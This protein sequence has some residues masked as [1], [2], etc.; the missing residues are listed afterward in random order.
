MFKAKILKLN[1][2]YLY[3]VAKLMHKHTRKK[4]LISLFAFFAPVK[5]IHTQSA[6][7][8]SSKSNLCQ[9]RY[10]SH[11]LQKNF[12]YQAVKMWNSLRTTKHKR[13]TLQS[14]Q[15]KLQK[16]FTFKYKSIYF[17]H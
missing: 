1:D 15:D 16:I 7:L 5:T 14:I 2:S 9:P 13:I 6:S 3:E 12:K 17:K 10:E 8:A 11:K 4:L